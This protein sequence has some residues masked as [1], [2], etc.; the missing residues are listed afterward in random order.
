M[1]LRLQSR[2]NAFCGSIELLIRLPTFYEVFELFISVYFRRI[3]FYF[4]DDLFR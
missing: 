4:I 3:S 2:L 1:H